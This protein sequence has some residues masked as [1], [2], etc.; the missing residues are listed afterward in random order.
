MA[1]G[2]ESA[3]APDAIAIYLMKM[4]MQ[5]SYARLISFYVVPEAEGHRL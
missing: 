5:V 2:H 1:V 3:H 4:V